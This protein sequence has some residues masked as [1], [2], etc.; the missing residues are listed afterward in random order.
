MD[1]RSNEIITSNKQTN[2]ETMERLIE[3]EQ[4][5]IGRYTDCCGITE[6]ILDHLDDED[7]EEYNK[8]HLEHY[9]TC[10]YCGTDFDCY[11]C[12][13]LLKKEENNEQ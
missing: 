4:I 12:R 5:A 11:Y 13:E 2:N 8:L 3:L 10:F 7:I 1:T 9:K 6:I